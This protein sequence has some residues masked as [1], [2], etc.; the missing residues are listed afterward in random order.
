MRKT[1]DGRR[2][3][4]REVKVDAVRRVKKGEKPSVVARSLNI[5]IELLSR[6]SRQVRAGGEEALKEVGRPKGMKTR[7]SAR[8]GEPNRVAELERLIGKQQ[9]TIDFLAQALR[10][11]EELRQS[12]KDDGATASSK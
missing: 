8:K 6:W 10:R 9:A 11:V 5:N 12:K 3:I 4:G 1:K 7:G 2:R